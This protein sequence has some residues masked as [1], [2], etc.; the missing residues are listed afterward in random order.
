M[1]LP[2]AS[3]RRTRRRVEIIAASSSRQTGCE[4]GSPALRS[5]MPRIE[6][7]F[8]FR[9]ERGA[10]RDAGDDLVE[11]SLVVNKQIAG[12]GAREDLDAGRALEL[13][14]CR[15]IGDVFARAADV[16]GEIGEHAVARARHLVGERFGTRRQRL[17]VGH[18]EHGRDA[19]RDRRPASRLQVFLVLEAR[20]AKVHLRIDDAG[21]QMQTLGVDRL[22][23]LGAAERPDRRD[24]PVL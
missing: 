1:R 13:F 24:P 5:P 11:G 21:E 12:R 9:V 4:E 7:R 20:L 19:A 2:C 3:A 17:G 18:L 10:A 14:E 8:V 22:G 15:N 6:P 16:E 23:G